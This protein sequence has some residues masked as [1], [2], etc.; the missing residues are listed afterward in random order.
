MLAGD[1]LVARYPGKYPVVFVCGDG[2]TMDRKKYLVDG[3]HTFAQ[4]M[5]LVRKSISLKRC[6]ALFAMVNNVLVPSSEIMRE[7]YSQYASQVDRILYIS[8]A[9]ENTFG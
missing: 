5:G 9:K 8:L 3:D 4:V 6:E 2:I 7:L 1:R